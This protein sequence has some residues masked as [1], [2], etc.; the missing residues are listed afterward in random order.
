MNK[1]AR[2]DRIGT[3]DDLLHDIFGNFLRPPTPPTGEM[4]I[5]LGQMHCLGA[6]AHLGNPTMSQVAEELRLHPST[7]VTTPR[8]QHLHCHHVWNRR[9]HRS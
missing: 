2:E 9:L 7:V 4:N 3:I 5:T 6:I 8:S 1:L